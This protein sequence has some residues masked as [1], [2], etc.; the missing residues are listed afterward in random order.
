MSLKSSKII[1]FKNTKMT[2]NGFNPSAVSL[3]EILR[4]LRPWNESLDESFIE[5]NI[6]WFSGEY[7]VNLEVEGPQIRLKDRQSSRKLKNAT[8]CLFNRLSD[9][10]F[11]KNILHRYLPSFLGETI[12]TQPTP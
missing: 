8:E 4:D 11:I 6:D 10:I 12:K 5:I 9:K 2:F 7:H 1:C 3:A